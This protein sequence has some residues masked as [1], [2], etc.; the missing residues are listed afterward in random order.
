MII[1]YID[2]ACE[3]YNPGG[4]MGWGGVAYQG[5]KKLFDFSNAC[6]KGKNNSNNKAEYLALETLLT[7]LLEDGLNNEEIYVRTDSMLIYWQMEPSREKKNRKKKYKGIYAEVAYACK[8]L[9]KENFPDI[10]IQWIPREKNGEADLLSK[11]TVY[12]DAKDLPSYEELCANSEKIDILEY[13]NQL[14]VA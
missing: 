5:N 1:C 14:T 7:I 9:I 10:H 6:R 3:P 11:E 13:Q 4:N 8:A 12:S 2:G